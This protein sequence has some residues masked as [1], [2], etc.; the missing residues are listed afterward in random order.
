[1]NV[2]RFSFKEL[3]GGAANA[4]RGNR[5]FK[6]P[7]KAKED[8]PPPPPTF[9][10]EQLKA[11]ERASYQ[12][13]FLEGEKEGRKQAESEQAMIDRKLTE[14]VE[15][16]ANRVAPIFNDYKK[17]ALA[18][19]QQSPKVALSIA[20]KIAGHALAQNAQA[21][22]DEIAL[23][24]SETMLKEPKLTITVHE[25]MG[26]TLARKLEQLAARLQSATDIVILR[27]PS[28]PMADCRIEWNQGEIERQT[29]QIWQQIEKTIEDMTATITRD[30]QEHMEKLWTQVSSTT[31]PVPEINADKKLDAINQPPTGKP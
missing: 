11:A 20:R 6:S 1:M 31:A 15:K 29:A 25:S 22:I 2:E 9:S 16:F 27:D 23:R 18:L 26:D 4:N 14:T 10:E 30:A 21:V 7:G 19:Q 17:M 12:K 3:N 8:A 24:C 28:M 5:P 13:G